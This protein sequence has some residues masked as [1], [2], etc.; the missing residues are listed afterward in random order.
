MCESNM[1]SKC[2]TYS[3]LW[4][5]APRSKATMQQN[6]T[7]GCLVARVNAVA[8]WLALPGIR[9]RNPMLLPGITC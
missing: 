3:C 9:L 7:L 4:V 5:F 1:V 8:G 2:Q 6:V